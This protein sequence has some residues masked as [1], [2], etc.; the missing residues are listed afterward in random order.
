MSKEAQINT[1]AA[2]N[3]DSQNKENINYY[4]NNYS[5]KKN[6]LNIKKTKQTKNPSS[7]QKLNINQEMIANTLFTTKE[8]TPN[9]NSNNNNN[10]N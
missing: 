3:I 4:P 6:I 1:N 7:S 10:P 8:N 9:N 2:N 5:D